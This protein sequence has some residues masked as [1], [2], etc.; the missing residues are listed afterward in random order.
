MGGMSRVL[1]HHRQG[2]PEQRW[3]SLP[4]DAGII[5]VGAIPYCF[6]SFLFI[7]W[8]NACFFLPWPLKYCKESLQYLIPPSKA[9]RSLGS[10]KE[11]VYLLGEVNE[12]R[13]EAG[14][15]RYK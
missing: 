8:L 5:L 4:D 6:I 10:P 14:A 12:I 13:R 2:G 3:G 9:G 15:P 7:W 1:S 11:M